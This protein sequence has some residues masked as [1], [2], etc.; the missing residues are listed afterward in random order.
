M[1][2]WLMNPTSLLQMYQQ[3]PKPATLLLGL[4]IVLASIA[5][6][7]AEN[8]IPAAYRGAWCL[9]DNAGSAPRF[10][11]AIACDSTPVRSRRISACAAHPQ[12]RCTSLL[13]ASRKKAGENGKGKG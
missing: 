3:N 11:S 7:R 10:V 12:T 9:T 8:T 13:R 1:F 6:A 2:P 4:A 5:A